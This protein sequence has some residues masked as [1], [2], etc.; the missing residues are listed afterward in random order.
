MLA[1]SGDVQVEA[2]RWGGLGL[3]PQFPVLSV[4]A[5]WSAL[6]PRRDHWKLRD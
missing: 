5:W 6:F 3:S 4:P 1:A 2:T